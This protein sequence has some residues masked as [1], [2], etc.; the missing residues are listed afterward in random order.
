VCA[1]ASMNKGESACVCT[2]VSVCVRTSPT[3]PN[4][5][6]GPSARW[7]TPSTRDEAL[8][9]LALRGT[10]RVLTGHAVVAGHASVAGRAGKARRAL[11]AR[12]AGAADAAGPAPKR[13]PSDRSSLPWVT[14]VRYIRTYV[15]MGILLPALASADEMGRRRAAAARAC[16]YFIDPSLRRAVQRLQYNIDI[17]MYIHTYM[18]SALEPRATAAGQQTSTQARANK[19]TSA[20]AATAALTR[21]RSRRRRCD[22]AFPR[23]PEC[24][25]AQRPRE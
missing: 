20:A 13:Q 9:V 18:L 1:C 3:R 22:R 14:H 16:L 5:L 19:Y 12:V 8:R 15:L 4:P 10:Q 23:R 17:Y 25:A 21:R 6:K 24:R 11:V 2:C 7:G